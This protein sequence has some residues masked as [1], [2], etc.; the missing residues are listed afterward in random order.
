MK[1]RNS[2]DGKVGAELFCNPLG[3]LVYPGVLPVFDLTRRV[4][5]ESIKVEIIARF[6]IGQ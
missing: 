5:W 3:Y 4:K 1:N 6:T 2:N